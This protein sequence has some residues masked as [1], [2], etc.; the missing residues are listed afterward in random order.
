MFQK[1]PR[2]LQGKCSEIRERISL[3]WGS[4]IRCFPNPEEAILS[5]LI[6]RNLEH[7]IKWGFRNP[8]GEVHF[9]LTGQI[10]SLSETIVG[11]TD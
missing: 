4:K 11:S 9:R 5:W 3:F 1:P 7:R 6:L 2:S 8:A 10:G